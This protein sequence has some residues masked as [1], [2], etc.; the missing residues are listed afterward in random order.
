[1]VLNSESNPRESADALSTV[2]EG[3]AYA[4]RVVGSKEPTSADTPLT[5]PQMVVL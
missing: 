1:M 2:A 4:L 3:P 5:E